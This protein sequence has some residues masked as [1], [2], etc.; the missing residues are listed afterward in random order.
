MRIA[1]AYPEHVGFDQARLL[2]T[3]ATVKALVQQGAEVN[4]IVGSFRGMKLRLTALGL[5]KLPGLNVQAISMWQK[6]PGKTLPLSWHGKYHRAC[7]TKLTKYNDQR[8]AAVVVRHLKLADYLLARKHRLAVPV[9]YE[10]HE[11]FCAT[12]QEEGMSGQKLADLEAMEKRVLA[13]AHKV[14]AISTP[15]AEELERAWNVTGNVEVLP[16]GVDE[17]FFQAAQT[18]RQDNLVAYAGGLG[19]W[20]GVDLLINA[21]A[22]TT[23]SPAL[24]ILGGKPDSEDW[25]RLSTLAELAGLGSRFTLRKRAGQDKVLELLERATI[26]VWPGTARQRIAAEFTSPLKLFEYMAAGCAIIAPDVPAARAILRPGVEAVFF[27]PDDPASLA[28][29]IDMLLADGGTRGE[30]G[31]AARELAHCFTWRERAKKIIRIAGELAA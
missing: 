9:I 23:A 30:M 29:A 10:A 8:P 15:L 4:F 26:A 17:S 21:V 20:K 3:C 7:I 28:D 31:R 22:E 2:Q 6:G 16:S 19:A 24:E 12:A 1:Y 5:D 11:L 25:K 27:E 18:K 14:T 13:S